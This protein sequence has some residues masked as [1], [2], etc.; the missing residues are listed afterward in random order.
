VASIEAGHASR[1]RPPDMVDRALAPRP[2]PL[3]L[4]MAFA[5]W[6]SSIAA[7]PG[8][9]G[10]WL[11][12]NGDPAA[13]RS[14]LGKALE[15]IPAE[16]FARALSDEAAWH[17]DAQLAGLEAYRRH[18]YRRALQDPPSIWVESASRLLDY[19]ECGAEAADGRPVLVVPSLV[20]RGYVP[21]LSEGYILIR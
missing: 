9:R 18:P 2:P 13:A 14:A 15:S 21:D 10:G 5:T 1:Y 16:A 12:S 20:N 6:T 11:A 17:A 3:H 19:G 4:A 8:S 7:W